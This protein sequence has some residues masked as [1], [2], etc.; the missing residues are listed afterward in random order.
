MKM[1]KIKTM[2]MTMAVMA[3][4]FSNNS[5]MAA[6]VEKAVVNE[7]TQENADSDKNAKKKFKES[8]TQKEIQDV[9]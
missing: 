2:I 5:V 8:K 7:E 3:S 6:E 1:S 4:L 9:K